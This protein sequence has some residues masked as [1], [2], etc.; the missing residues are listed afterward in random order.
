VEPA[1]D[2]ISLASGRN[3]ADLLEARGFGLIHES[4]N[5]RSVWTRVMVDR[6][7]RSSLSDESGRPAVV[8]QWNADLDDRAAEW[9]L[10]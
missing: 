10:D 8:A 4:M 5:V 6:S 1:D 2:H 7:Q 3:L 9:E